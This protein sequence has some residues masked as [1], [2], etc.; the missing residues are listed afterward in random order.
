MM[1]GEHPGI[2]MCRRMRT[3]RGRRGTGSPALWPFLA[4]FS[5][6]KG[7]GHLTRIRYDPDG[8]APLQ[9]G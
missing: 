6:R 5:S 7:R 1:K 4:T 2:F 3:N 9:Q 8:P